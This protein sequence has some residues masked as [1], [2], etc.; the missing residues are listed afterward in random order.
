MTGLLAAGCEKVNSLY[1]DESITE[2]EVSFDHYNSIW[3]YGIFDIR[4]VEDTV[5]KMVVT[6]RRS[7][8]D[9]ITYTQ[10]NRKIIIEENK[11][12]QWYRG[13]EKPVLEFHFRE[14]R[15]FRIEEP[16]RLR[17]LDT[18][19]S[20]NL[21]VIVANEL[22]EVDL[23]MD[24]GTFYME[25]WS[26]NTGEYTL[27]GRCE[28]FSVKLCGSGSLHAEGLET[29]HAVIEQ[30]SIGKGYLSVKDTLEVYSSSQGDIYYAGN[31][32]K[33]I[34]EQNA[35]GELIRMY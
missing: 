23:T 20:D 17:S 34:F 19:H 28:N 10:K 16:S 22:S 6:G 26:T 8:V 2:K 35:S 21:Q 7:V 13:I 18:I 30:Q 31:P 5:Y 11:K 12:N 3:T 27:S 9:N 29:S 33:I 15:Y 1:T 14:L 25:N 4:L 24:A 32:K